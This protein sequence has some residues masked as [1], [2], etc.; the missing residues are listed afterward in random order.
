[1]TKEFTNIAA[2][3]QA[4]RDEDP[5]RLLLQQ[6]RHPGVDMRLVAQQLEGLAQAP[7]KWPSWSAC[8]EV[9]YPPK[10][11]REQSSSEVAAR[12]K[13]SLLR[14]DEAE[15]VD[16]TGGMGVDTYFMALRTGRMH[17]CEQDPNLCQLATHNFAALGQTNILVHEGDS[18]EWLKAT[19]GRV[20]AYI[21]IDP[22]RRDS[23]GSRTTAFENCTPNLL[24]WLPLL[25]SRCERLLVKA[26]PMLDLHLA[27]AQLGEVAEV[28]IVA[29][30]SECKEML[31]ASGSGETQIVC[32]N[33]R[34][35]GR[36]EHR[37]TLAEEQAAPYRAAPCVQ[38]YLYEP[39][40]ALMKGGCY[41]LLAQWYDLGA[42]DTHSHLY[43]AE[44]LRED[45]PGRILE[46]ECTTRLD[47]KVLRQL[48][49]EGKAHVICRNYPA[50]ADRLQQQLGLTEGGGH[51]LVATTCAGQRTG[52]LC[53]LVRS[54]VR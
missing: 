5:V 21:Y 49:P 43:T 10:L 18:L 45:F 13:A 11:N 12:Y 39:H 26:S 41:R 16:L 44:H 1:M 8:P 25:R 4:H 35:T 7:A 17:Y 3:A 36:D 30:A 27:M 32:V 38:R 40:A 2:F 51:Y 52:L 50:R 9:C 24:K 19:D 6:D 47:R 48:L 28:H 53:R 22:A 14:G 54:A 34:P 29:V 15:G 23:Y 46:V 37:F 20:F 33:L 42:L 31:L